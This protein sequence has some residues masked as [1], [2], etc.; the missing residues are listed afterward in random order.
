M[1]ASIALV[2][3]RKDAGPNQ[4]KLVRL[5][6]PHLS[7]QCPVRVPRRGPPMALR[8]PLGAPK[9]PF[10]V[11]TIIYTAPMPARHCLRPRE[12]RRRY[13]CVSRRDGR[14]QAG[15]RTLRDAALRT[16]RHRMRTRT[17]QSTR[18]DSGGKCSRMRRPKAV[19]RK[20]QTQ[21]ARFE[22]AHR[23]GTA[24]CSF[25][26][27]SAITERVIGTLVDDIGPL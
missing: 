21:R 5:A 15:S 8:S 20:P 23:G 1:L 4:T 22:Q 6:N 7:Q 27:S 12:G 13:K 9:N 25:A 26:S 17:S 11:H 2:A 10:F 16:G 24:R 18:R 3:P 14:P 19:N